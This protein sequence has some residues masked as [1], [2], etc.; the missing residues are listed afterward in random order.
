MDALLDRDWDNAKNEDAI[1]Y[2][3][4]KVI[5]PISIMRD[6]SKTPIEISIKKRDS[7]ATMNIPN[8]KEWV[9]SYVNTRVFQKKTHSNALSEWAVMGN[10]AIVLEKLAGLA[11]PEQWDIATVG[12][13]LTPKHTILKS[14]LT[15]TFYRLQQEDKVQINREKGI[16]AFNTG[17]V[18]RTYEPIY[19]CFTA[20][21]ED[22]KWKF[23]DFCK[24][25]SRQWG[26]KLVA[27]FNPL[28]QRAS[29]FARKEDLLF[30]TDAPFERD[31]DHILLDNINR[32]PY[33]FL[34]DEMRNVQEAQNLLKTAYSSP[35]SQERKAAFEELEDIIQ[36]DSRVKRR[37]MNRLDDAIE[38]ARKRVEWNYKT[39]V[40][41]FYP[42]RN[43]MC[44]LLPLDLTDDDKPDV[45]LVAELTESGAYLGQTII[46]MNMAYNNARL[47][48]RPDSDWLS[49]SDTYRY[50][51][52]EDLLLDE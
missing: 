30:D 27:T 45:A 13:K 37:L 4:G 14:Y 6:D 3:E 39:A 22:K 31:T 12:K 42:S 21:D 19:A 34:A 28:P 33:E 1:R 29:Y 8:P 9:V 49:T 11:L 17:L 35:N 24:A 25:G 47:I 48:A 44:I 15:Y 41:A 38:L 10:W 43:V 23:Q 32:L 2:Y 52:D 40:P 51:E 46:T 7:Y 36:D 16:C 26:K 18:N 5:F 50:S 20:I